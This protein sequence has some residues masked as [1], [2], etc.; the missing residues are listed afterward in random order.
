MRSS[1]KIWVTN[2]NVEIIYSLKKKECIPIND[3][4][5][6]YMEQLYKSWEK[7]ESNN[8]LEDC[9]HE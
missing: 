7:L 9:E 2:E 5:E 6:N 4:A 3:M 1:P 8:R